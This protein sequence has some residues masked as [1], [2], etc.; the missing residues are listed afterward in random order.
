MITILTNRR[1]KHSASAKLCVSLAENSSYIQKNYVLLKL[2]VTL[3]TVYRSVS[4]IGK[5]KLLSKKRHVNLRYNF[6]SINTY[7][8]N[9]LYMQNMWR[10]KTCLSKSFSVCYE[11]F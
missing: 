5:V 2:S 6:I 1:L 7:S 9:H 11:D 10:L 3:T 8:N 4:V